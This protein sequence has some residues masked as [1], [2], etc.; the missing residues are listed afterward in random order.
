MNKKIRRQIGACHTTQQKGSEAP[1]RFDYISAIRSMEICLRSSGLNVKI[2]KI[3]RRSCQRVSIS[4]RIERRK[5][6]HKETR[7][8]WNSHKI[9]F[10]SKCLQFGYTKLLQRYVFMHSRRHVV[11][12]ILETAILPT[13]CI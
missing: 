12:A 10:V 3:I 9:D 1:V 8:R 7:E 11:T 2:L 4:L 13:I 6:A 5:Q